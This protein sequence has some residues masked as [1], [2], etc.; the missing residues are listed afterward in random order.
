MT[1]PAGSPRVA[2]AAA[3]Y[4]LHGNQ[5]ADL[6][7]QLLSL[8]PPTARNRFVCYPITGS[9][10]FADLGRTT[11]LQVFEEAFG[12]DRGLMEREYGPYEHASQFF[13]VMDTERR[14]PAGVL[15]II[16]NSSAGL[17][18]LR[19]VA[20]EPL[21]IPR[22][23]FQAFHG[24]EDLDRCWDVGTVAVLPE[25]RRSATRRRTVSLLLYRAFYV[26][27]LDRG[28]DHVVAV[29]DRYAH[30]S[31]RALGI[32]LVPLCGSTPFSYLDSA[33]STALYGH[34]PE[35]RAKA[36]AHYRRLR[37]RRPLLWCLLSRPL[38]QLIRG[39]GLDDR[40]QPLVDGDTVDEALEEAPEEAESA[41]L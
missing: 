41:R 36:E 3:R 31:L 4:E 10:R 37:A 35:F 40:L 19:D 5:A 20:G 23:D 11:E 12:N 8:H 2:G 39:T 26:H 21:R 33:S 28:I 1:G 17:K 9:S 30:R 34:V 15:R 29:I 18:T 13:V 16:G 14:Q 7:E 38:R 27:A 22:E 32:P 6:S 24:V 25:Y